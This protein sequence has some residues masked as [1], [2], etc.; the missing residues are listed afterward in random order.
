MRKY[1]PANVV[2]AASPSRAEM[3]SIY[4]LSRSNRSATTWKSWPW[5][6]NLG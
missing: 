5:A 1:S 3:I 4:S 2:G 6:R